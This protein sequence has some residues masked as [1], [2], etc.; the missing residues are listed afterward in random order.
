MMQKI[1]GVTELQRRFKAVFD[2]VVKQRTPY[3]LARG[4]RPEAALIPYD[5]FLRYQELEEKDREFQARWIELRER[6][7][8]QKDLT[9]EQI[10]AEVA[11]AVADVAEARAER[12]AKG[13][14][15]PSWPEELRFIRQRGK[16]PPG[17]AGL[18]WTRGELYDR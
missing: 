16:L 5:N 1:I 2:E 9:D 11:A 18:R 15:E 14:D 12:R 7:A 3:V 17:G 13:G 10:E 8:E 6:L 4:S